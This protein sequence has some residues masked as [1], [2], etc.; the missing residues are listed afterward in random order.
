MK[1]RKVVRYSDDEDEQ[2]KVRR[3]M[4]ELCCAHLFVSVGV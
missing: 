2:V 3:R 4:P 1:K